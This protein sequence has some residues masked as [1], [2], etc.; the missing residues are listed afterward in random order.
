MADRILIQELQVHSRIGVTP[1]ERRRPQRLRITVEMAHPLKKAGTTDELRRTIDYDSVARAM[2][3]LAAKKERR[4]IE[5]LAEE[6]A[7]LVLSRFGA[8]SVSVTVKKFV[9]PDA[10]CVAV[11]IERRRKKA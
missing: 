6:A 3:A 9:L 10:Q 7:R 2:R 4:L 8:G 11:T 1:A 5:S